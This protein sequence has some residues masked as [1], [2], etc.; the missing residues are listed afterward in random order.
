[1]VGEFL[2][3]LNFELVKPV[4]QFDHGDGEVRMAVEIALEPNSSEQDFH[5]SLFPTLFFA[6]K[7]FPYLNFVSTGAMQP[8]FAAD[9]AAAAV[10]SL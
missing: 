6:D 10:T 9:Q 5:D 7:I 4:L 3:R 1:M 8:E 2:H